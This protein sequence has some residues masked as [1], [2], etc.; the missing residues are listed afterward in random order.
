MVSVQVF[1]LF[2]VAELLG[3]QLHLARHQSMV[4]V[5]VSIVLCAGEKYELTDHAQLVLVL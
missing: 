3:L 5:S 1:L 4:S 2:S